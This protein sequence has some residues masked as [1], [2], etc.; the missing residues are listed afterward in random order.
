MGDKKYSWYS[1]LI[2]LFIDVGIRM[3]II[4]LAI[5]WLILN[6][7]VPSITY[8]SW[9]IAGLFWSLFYPIER[10]YDKLEVEK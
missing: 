5:D 3:F 6:L 1:G 9:G 2:L 4:V 10:F 8:Y 7:D